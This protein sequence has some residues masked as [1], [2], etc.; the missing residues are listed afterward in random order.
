M[1]QRGQKIVVLESSAK[2]GIR[3][4]AGDV[5]YLDNLYLFPGLRFILLD[6]FFFAY[7]GDNR[8]RV[9]KKKFMIDL[10]MNRNIRFKIS[11]GGMPVKF[12]IDNIDLVNL[13]SVGYRMRTPNKGNQLF[14]SYPQM[15]SNYGIWPLL[16]KRLEVN[17]VE[18]KIVKIPYGQIALFNT[19]FTH[20]YSM[21]ECDEVELTAWLRS[22]MPMVGSALNVLCD[23]SH[24][25]P[26]DPMENSYF[27]L[28]RKMWSEIFSGVMSFDFPPTDAARYGN[29]CDSISAY[30]FGRFSSNRSQ[31]KKV[32]ELL[33]KNVNH[34]N[35][36]TSVFLQRLDSYHLNGYLNPEVN[37]I[38]DFLAS[39]WKSCG[40]MDGASSVDL[41]FPSCL[42]LYNLIR[43]IFFRAA[44]MPNNTYARLKPLA[45]CLPEEWQKDDELN[46][47]I[48][49]LDGIKADADSDSSALDRIYEIIK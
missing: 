42:H 30:R 29:T 47:R 28:A 31:Y 32:A 3:P 12:F 43:S 8:D 46:C 1:F 7:N 15:Y 48:K 10:G 18:D 34:L 45:H 33:V 14:T 38:V 2:S 23:Y 13:S 19:K 36:L 20:K 21:V 4:R 44:I 22:M 41:S 40:I 9:E 16:K 24:F 11:H 25:Y 5:G 6:A 26:L 49:I 37:H 17:P 39:M 27:D 35:S